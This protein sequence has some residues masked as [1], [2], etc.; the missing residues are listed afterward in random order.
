MN[1]KEPTD[2]NT[3]GNNDGDG[4]SSEIDERKR[5]LEK[6]EGDYG[7][8]N[9]L[10]ESN[11]EEDLGEG[12]MKE[13]NKEPTQIEQELEQA[14]RKIKQAKTKEG[15]TKTE[16]GQ[17]KM[18]N[19]REKTDEDGQ[20]DG[21]SNVSRGG[22]RGEPSDLDVFLAFISSLPD[23]ELEDEAVKTT[24][25]SVTRR[26]AEGRTNMNPIVAAS[27]VFEETDEDLLDRLETAVDNA[28]W[29]ARIVFTATRKASQNSLL[30]G[31]RMGARMTNTALTTRSLDE[32]LSEYQEIT[33]DGLDELSNGEIRGE[34]FLPDDL[35]QVDTES[36]DNERNGTTEEESFEKMRDLR[37]RGTHLLEMSADVEND[38]LHHPAFSHILDQISPDEARVLRFIATDGPQPAVDVRSKG[39]LPI[40]SDLV[41]AGL[42]ML[43]T[44]AGCRH[45][46][47]IQAYLNNLEHL[48][49][50]W[51]STESIED[52][53]RYQ[54]LEAQPDVKEAMDKCK[55]A[56]IKRRSILLTPLGVD[57]CRVC[58]PIEVHP[59]NLAEAYKIPDDRYREGGKS[60]EEFMRNTRRSDSYDIP[61]GI[62][63]PY[64]NE[65]D[66]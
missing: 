19:G 25:K 52:Y 65:G 61:E 58:F 4:Y 66:R 43:A 30:T 54:L 3:E 38:E 29:M 48:G 10:D 11:I 59:G 57:F 9:R 34:D 27:V 44:E 49:V 22:N 32:F 2:M 5:D 36:S 16:G 46:D 1:R 26:M 6:D 56:K 7:E 55:R 40:G 20:E 33:F 14:K 23:R 28:F 18:E 63:N 17:A 24:V 60:K 12:E 35:V 37:E 21:N 31:L 62:K 53:K 39:W 13:A 42:T 50:I 15:Q 47:R 41:G 51:F 64:T 45:E 8:S